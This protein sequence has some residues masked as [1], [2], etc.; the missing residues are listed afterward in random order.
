M[1]SFPDN[2]Q[3]INDVKFVGDMLIKEV[4]DTYHALVHQSQSRNR[5][6]P[7]PRL[8]LDEFYNVSKFTTGI[9]D[10]KVNV[11]AR[12]YN[13]V[14]DALN[15]DALND[16][17]HLPRYLIIALDKDV[18]KDLSEL[19]FGVT[20]NLTSILNWLTRKI[21]IAVRRKRC[22]INEK[23]PGATGS[24]KDPTIIYIDMI[25]CIGMSQCIGMPKD[26]L[27]LKSILDLRFKFNS[28]LQAAIENQDDRVMSIRS[29][30]T[31]NHFD[32]AGNLT[33]RGK[34][35]FW[36]EVDDLLA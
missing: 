1:F 2:I 34:I 32:A 21:D 14:I 31:A 12:I 13:S 19:E 6:K 26:N 33:N 36:H 29:C 15:D 35:A 3:A 27:K 7:I 5:E 8:Y 20:K 22:Q 16:D 28:I 11:T 10:L 24:Q 25:Q 23:K 18:L 4:F 30:A 9:S 17:A